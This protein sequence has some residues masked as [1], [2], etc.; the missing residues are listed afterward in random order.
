MNNIMIQ[1]KT[2][3]IYILNFQKNYL[4]YAILC[5]FL[6]GFMMQIESIW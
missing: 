1:N 4:F 5:S 6:C 2:I 3:F